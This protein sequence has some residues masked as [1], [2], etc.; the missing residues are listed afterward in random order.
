MKF[1]ILTHVQHKLTDGSVSAYAPYVKEMNIWLKHVDEVSIVAP[2]TSEIKNDIDLDYEH[3]TLNFNEIPSIE[4]TNTKKILSSLF[5]L[6]FI[7]SV[8]FKACKKADHIHLRCP[9]NI[10]LIGCLVQ[11]CFPKKI[12]TAKYAGN[13]DPH[14]HQ[15]WSYRL[16]QTIL[17]NTFLTRNMKVLVY[18]EWPNQSKNIV[19]FF[20]ASY[21]EIEKEGMTV[22][23]FYKS[24][25]NSTTLNQTNNDLIKLLFVGSFFL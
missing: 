10:G 20:T 23:E 1:L 12:K 25:S 7:C 3:K 13:W 5:K 17:R 22:K 16:Q 14:S 18:G 9:G 21:S 4:F 2:K 24:F 6:P 11:I 15:P 8:I 19:P